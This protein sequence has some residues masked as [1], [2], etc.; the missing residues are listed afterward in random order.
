M[1]N[2]P[3]GDGLSERMDFLIK[4]SERIAAMNERTAIIDILKD[5][6]KWQEAKTDNQEVWEAIYRVTRA[7]E[8]RQQAQKEQNK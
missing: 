2:T 8:A 1:S 6:L 4:C 7:I 3:I 5:E